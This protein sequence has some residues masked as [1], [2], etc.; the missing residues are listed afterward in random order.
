M[1]QT[2]TQGKNTPV[3]QQNTWQKPH[4]YVPQFCQLQNFVVECQKSFLEVNLEK[5]AQDNFD[6]YVVTDRLTGKRGQH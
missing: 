1:Q 3:D 4:F 6:R 5:S 2:S